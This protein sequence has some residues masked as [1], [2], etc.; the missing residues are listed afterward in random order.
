MAEKLNQTEILKEADRFSDLHKC[1]REPVYKFP[2]DLDAISG[3]KWQGGEEVADCVNLF[4]VNCFFDLD[5]APDSLPGSLNNTLTKFLGKSPEAE[6]LINLAECFTSASLD[7]FT[8]ALAKQL[9]KIVKGREVQTRDIKKALIVFGL[10]GGDKA[11]AVLFKGRVYAVKHR[12]GLNPVFDATL[13]LGNTP[14]TGLL[15]RIFNYCAPSVTILKNIKKIRNILTDESLLSDKNSIKKKK[16]EEYQVSSPVRKHVEKLITGLYLDIIQDNLFVFK[17]LTYKEWRV[18]FVDDIC[19]LRLARTLLW[20]FYEQQHLRQVFTVNLNGELINDQGELVEVSESAGMLINPVHPIEMT[21]VEI[22]GWRGYFSEAGLPL[23]VEQ[24]D[25]SLFHKNEYPLHRYLSKP[26]ILP[27]NFWKRK[28]GWWYT[29][30]ESG[31]IFSF[32]RDF[33]IKKG[34]FFKI[35]I[36]T[37]IDRRNPHEEDPFLEDIQLLEPDSNTISDSDNPETIPERTY[38]ELCREL[39]KYFLRRL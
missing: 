20:G 34:K 29:E 36:K 38:S 5:N 22:D 9:V 33:V 31:V 12:R 4:M 17:D 6:K 37:Y 8:E 2:L 25:L 30:E 3:L 19:G 32:Q 39:E 14:Y 13:R 10:L 35:V 16:L 28:M 24:L 15:Y 7:D 23:L 27:E 11:F 21:A 18:L 26:E 1:K